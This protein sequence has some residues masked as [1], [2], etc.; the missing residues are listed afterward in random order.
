[1]ATILYLGFLK[2]QIGTS[3]T[4]NSPIKISIIIIINDPKWNL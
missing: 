2:I 4:L 3:V 1:M